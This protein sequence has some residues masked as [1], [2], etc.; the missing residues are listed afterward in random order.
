MLVDEAGRFVSQREEPRLARVVP[1]LALREL[2]LASSGKKPL[3]LPL[4]I[5]DGER[6]DVTIWKSTVQALVHREGSRWFS[7]LLECELELVFMPG[8]SERQIDLDYAEPGE[9]VS[10]ADGFPLL[11]AGQSSLDELNLRL[12]APV[13]MRRFRPNLVVRGAAAYAEDEWTPS[14]SGRRRAAPGQAVHALCGHD[15]GP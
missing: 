10:F 15:L 12:E 14:P 13:E 4:E 8:T 1:K 6:L 2:E 11:L 3:A 5:S 7:E 9:I